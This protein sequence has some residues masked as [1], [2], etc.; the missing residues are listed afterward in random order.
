MAR[1]RPHPGLQKRA[2]PLSVEAWPQMIA[3]GL[4]SKRAEL[5]RGV[6]I[7]KMSKSFEV[8]NSRTAHPS[9]T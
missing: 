8:I 4:V 6:I 2:M 1:I 3:G 7:E 9:L 5:I